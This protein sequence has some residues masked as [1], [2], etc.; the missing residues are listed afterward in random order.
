MRSANAAAS[1]SGTPRLADG[2]HVE[3]CA[4]IVPRP[5][6]WAGPSSLRLVAP[7]PPSSQPEE[8]SAAGGAPVGRRSRALG[9]IGAASFVTIAAAALFA[10]TWWP[11]IHGSRVL[12]GADTLS[13][14]RQPWD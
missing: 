9:R 5:P 6:R 13:S 2:Y 8:T 12:P 14:C 7:D 3:C 1:A 11:V 10:A 4:D